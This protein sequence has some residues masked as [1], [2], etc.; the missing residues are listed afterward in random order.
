MGE[1]RPPKRSDDPNDLERELTDE[2]VRRRAWAAVA[3]YLFVGIAVA[4]ALI[5]D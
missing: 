1:E 5:I 3:L 4:I 2:E